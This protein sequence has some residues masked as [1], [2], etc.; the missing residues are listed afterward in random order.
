VDNVC[1]TLVGAALGEAGLKQRTRHASATLMI[2]ANLPDLDVLV[3]FTE[4]SSFSFRRGWT[5]GVL[6]QALLPVA[7]TV[8]IWLGSRLWR[9][10]TAND[11]RPP[12]HPGWLFGL[13]WIGVVSHVG[14]DYLNN[15]GVRW[16]SPLDWRWFYGDALFIIDP[17][18]WLALGA[19][20]WLARRQR[21]PVPARAALIFAACYT[22]AMLGSARAARTVVADVWRETRGTEARGLMVGPLPITPFS[23]TVIV[24]AGDRYETGTLSWWSNRVAFD[25]EAIPKNDT[26]PAVV[27]ARAQSLAI[28]EFLVWSRFPFYTVRA[29]DDGTRVSVVDARFMGRGARFEVS[30]TVR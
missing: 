29:A 3:F 6:G 30:T 21:A 8:V 7:L 12:L 14:L 2:A 16:L 5:H 15:Y 10:D 26:L 28:R 20:T 27:T 23:R 22:A 18:L 1:H 4:T 13:S 25:G 9:R 24:D 19:G 17:W 11:P